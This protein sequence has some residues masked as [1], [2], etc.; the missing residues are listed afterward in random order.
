MNK[1]L[2]GLIIA[3]L[4]SI[5]A[6]LPTYS[7]R[8]LPKDIN[9]PSG[10][11]HANAASLNFVYESELPKTFRSVKTS[12][13]SKVHLINRTDNY[14]CLAIINADGN[15]QHGWTDGN[16]GIPV[17]F[18]APGKRT[19]QQNPYCPAVGQP[20]AILTTS[21]EIIGYGQVTS[22]GEYDLIIE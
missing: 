7:Q 5:F 14:I 21:G 17:L 9:S 13:T 2:Q 15:L 20:F 10:K 12:G 6:A 16:A 8:P 22:E 19:N 1:K 4:L 11:K 3:S 18:V